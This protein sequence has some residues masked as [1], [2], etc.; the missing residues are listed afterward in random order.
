MTVAYVFPGQGAQYLGMGVDIAAHYPQA[1]A[2]YNRASAVLGCDLLALCRRGPKALL[3]QTETAQPAILVTSLACWIAGQT[4]LPQPQVVAGLSL[5]E[6]TALVAAGALEVEQAVEL[7][8]QRGR[9]MQEATADRDVAMAAILGLEATQV[10]L[11]CEQVTRSGGLCQTA[12]YNAPTQI[13]VSGDAPAVAQ[14]SELAIAAGASGAVPLAVSGAFHTCLMQPAATRLAALLETIKI[15]DPDLPIVANVTARPVHQAEEIRQLLI[16][17]VA[18]P[19]RW[20]Q[21][22]QFMVQQGIE[23]FIE[24]GPGRK[25]S[26][27][28]KRTARGVNILNV[29][30]CSSMQATVASVRELATAKVA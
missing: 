10:E 23:T 9:Y 14:V 17:Q 11:L 1:K 25:L 7:I 20:V 27:M 18:N 16:Q 13:V 3:Q 5:G 28:I 24:F 4:E 29:E 26:G 2:L 15:R 22:V 6:Y 8:Q 30:N 12:N 21:S 19:V